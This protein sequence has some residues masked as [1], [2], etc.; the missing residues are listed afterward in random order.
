VLILNLFVQKPKMH[1]FLPCVGSLLTTGQNSISLNTE[2]LTF[3]SIRSYQKRAVCTCVFC[4]RNCSFLVTSDSKLESF[5]T[6]CNI[7]NKQQPSVRLCYVAPLKPGQLSHRFM[8]VLFDMECTVVLEQRDGYFEHEPNRIC[9]QQMCSN[10]EAIE[11]LNIDCSQSGTRVHVF[12]Q[13]HIG[14]FI[15]Y[16]LQFRTFADKIYVISHNYGG[17]D[18]EFCGEGLWN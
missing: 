17:Y 3:G 6:F 4:M 11:D 2:V 13:D 10:C 14:K 5:K 1:S 16:L 8:Y 12:R 7:C 18:T 9:D 15:E